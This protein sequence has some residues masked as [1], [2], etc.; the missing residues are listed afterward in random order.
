MDDYSVRL[1]QTLRVLMHREQIDARDLADRLGR[2]YE[3]VRRWVSGTA[4]P[5]PDAIADLADALGVPADPLLRPPATQ[6]EVWAQVEAWR[7][8]RRASRTRGA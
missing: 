2:N 8:V 5:R 6:D 4:A 1:G 3:V 7:A